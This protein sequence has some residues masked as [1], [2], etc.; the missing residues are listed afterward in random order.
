MSSL[1]AFTIAEETKKQI[2]TLARQTGKPEK[3]VMREVFETGL[4]NYTTTP[5]TSVQAALDL[6]EWAEKNDLR[7]P[8]DLSTNHNKY[9]WEE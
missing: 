5:T 7:G 6:I 8:K 9:A 1:V 4:K 2:H 3:V